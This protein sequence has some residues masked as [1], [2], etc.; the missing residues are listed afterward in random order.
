MREPAH[1]L[2]LVTNTIVRPRQLDLRPDRHHDECGSVSG[3]E[4][5]E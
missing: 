2:Q 3:R 4:A 1:A 5:T